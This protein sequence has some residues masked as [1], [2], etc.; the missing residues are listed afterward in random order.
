[1]KNPGLSPN[2]EFDNQN[3]GATAHVLSESGADVLPTTTE[4]NGE[5]GLVKSGV[6]LVNDEILLPAKVDIRQEVIDAAVKTIK[7]T[8]GQVQAVIN[9]YKTYK[10]PALDAPNYKIELAQVDVDRKSLKAFRIEAGK[11]AKDLK[12]DAW[13]YVTAINSGLKEYETLIEPQETALEV[14]HKQGTEALTKAENDKRN[15]RILSLTDVGF[16]LAEG[17]YVCGDKALKYTDL[18]KVSDADINALVEFG[19]KVIAEKE[20]K[21]AAEEKAKKK[22][23]NLKAELDAREQAIIAKEIELGL[24]PK[25]EEPK[26]E[27]V[28]PETQTR[29]SAIR[30]VA[31]KPP[32]ETTVAD[33]S[34]VPAS[35][36]TNGSIPP[37][38]N[39]FANEADDEFKMEREE[40]ENY[41]HYPSFVGGFNQLRER[42]L[43]A[44]AD[45]QFKEA[46]DL[47]NWL[48]KAEPEVEL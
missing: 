41:F 15:N 34:F 10:L 7:K 1:M 33:K 47:V 5:N 36:P 37:P 6:E 45:K 35:A 46:S 4:I 11:D 29:P 28:K 16:E 44:I 40:D 27:E 20:A 25:P 42:L 18:M 14:L 30:V 8:S 31:A 32:V 2:L 3:D 38:A 26:P 21:L 39:L 23:E 9:K 24:R 48:N 12:A 13:A 43:G 19:K 17:Q 22:L